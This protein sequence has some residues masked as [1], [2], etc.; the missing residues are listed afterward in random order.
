[1]INDAR[2]TLISVKRATDAAANAENG[3]EARLGK[4]LVFLLGLR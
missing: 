3:R 2:A 1:M 4:T